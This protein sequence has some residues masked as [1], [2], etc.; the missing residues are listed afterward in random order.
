MANE[1]V[2]NDEN[3][4]KLFMAMGYKERLK[5]LK[6]PIRTEAQRIRRIVQSKVRDSGVRAANDLA[7]FVRVKLTKEGAGFLV[8]MGPG[9]NGKFYTN[10]RG[11]KKPVLLF[12]E[13]GALNRTTLGKRERRKHST[14]DLFRAKGGHGFG[15]IPEVQAAEGPKVT[16]NIHKNIIDYMTNEAKKYGCR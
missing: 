1:F 2:Y 15:I 11:L 14:G 13:A 7:K 6:K 9:R 4:Q 10:R 16:D 5:A 8:S 12:L 3:L